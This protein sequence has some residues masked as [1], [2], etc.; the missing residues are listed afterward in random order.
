M[1]AVYELLVH[2]ILTQ[3]TVKHSACPKPGR[4]LGN[5]CFRTFYPSTLPWF[6]PA[7]LFQDLSD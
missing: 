2:G 7:Y 6:T 4:P 3:Q 5:F 1:L